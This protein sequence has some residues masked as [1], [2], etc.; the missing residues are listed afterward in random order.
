MMTQKEMTTELVI[1]AIEEM[2]GNIS[3]VAKKLKTSRPTVYNFINAHPTCK[4]ALEA[5]REA[6][7]DNAESVLYKKVLDGEA[8]AVCFFLKTQAKHRGYSER[9]E[10]TGDGGGEI[11]LRVV[12]DDDKND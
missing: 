4:T 1:A 12:Y 8:W 6:M 10:V 9:H 11:I 2:R 3:A 5:S 7:I